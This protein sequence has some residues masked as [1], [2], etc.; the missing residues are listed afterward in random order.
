RQAWPGENPIG[1][2][3]RREVPG[4]P[5]TPWLTVVGVVRDTKEDRF[6]FRINRPVWYLPYAQQTLPPPI[7]LPLNLA[8]RVSGGAGGVAA[9]LRAAVRAVDPGQPIMRVASLEERL[10]DVLLPERFGAVL[11]GALAAIGLVLAG[12]GLYGLLAFTVRQRTPEIGVR[13]AMGA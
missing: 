9:A 13:V 11:M 2:R 3:I 5:D 10:A 4:H 12:V 8:V 7:E 6:N 1:K